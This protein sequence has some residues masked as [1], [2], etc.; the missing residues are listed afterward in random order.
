MISLKIALSLKCFKN[1]L[2]LVL[3]KM[4]Q[5]DNN[6]FNYKDVIEIEAYLIW[7]EKSYTAFIP[8]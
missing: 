7:G 8:Y 5:K 6:S 3:T 4:Q 2:K 1:E